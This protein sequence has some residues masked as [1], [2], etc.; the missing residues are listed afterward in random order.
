MSGKGNRDINKNNQMSLSSITKIRKISGTSQFSA[1][2]LSKI[3]KSI[4]LH[5]N[6]YTYLYINK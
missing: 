3:C 5:I 1:D 2:Y 6:I 4:N